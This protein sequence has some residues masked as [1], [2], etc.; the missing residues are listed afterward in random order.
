MATGSYKKGAE[1]LARAV[2]A[3]IRA[4][5]ITSA[6]RIARDLNQRGYATPRG[7]V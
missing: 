3:K 1:L 4:S 6:N 5:G 7:G 2:I